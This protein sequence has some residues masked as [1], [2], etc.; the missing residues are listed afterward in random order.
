MFKRVINFYKYFKWL[1]KYIRLY[2]IDITIEYT[3]LSNYLKFFNKDR[4]Y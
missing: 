4:Y 2:Y 3:I 1:N